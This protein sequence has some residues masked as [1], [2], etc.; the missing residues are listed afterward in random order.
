MSRSRSTRPSRLKE[1][2]QIALVVAAGC[3]LGCG[4]TG[5]VPSETD[6]G[7]LYAGDPCRWTES[8]PDLDFPTCSVIETNELIGTL[9]GKPF[10]ELQSGN[11]LAGPVAPIEP[12]SAT[13]PL[14]GYGSIDF[15]WGDPWISGR[16][17]DV[18]GT[19][20]VTLGS[21][22]RDLLPGSQ[23]LHKCYESAYLFIIKVDGG[24]LLGCAR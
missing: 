12:Y 13:L 14:S 1:P 19:L 5:E 6:G 15:V 3:A 21:T 17:T 9:D 16:W 7:T 18:T 8:R 20:T 23:L 4:T 22:P 2:L 11:F 24:D 10:H